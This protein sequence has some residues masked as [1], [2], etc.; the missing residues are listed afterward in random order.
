MA[1]SPAPPGGGA[2]AFTDDIAAQEAAEARRARN[3]IGL[4]ALLLVIAAVASAVAVIR[5]VEDAGERELRA[6]QV[7][8]GIVAD[9]RASA[10]ADWVKAQA[11]EIAAIAANPS[12][13]LTMTELAMAD[14][15]RS[16]LIDFDGQAAYLRNYLTSV[17]ER[18]G[19]SRPPASDVDFQAGGG[20]RTMGIA[21]VDPHGMLVSATRDMPL[22]EGEI[23]DW[24]RT[25][26]RDGPTFIDAHAAEGAVRIGFLAPIYR[27]QMPSESANYTGMVIGLR[28]LDDGFRALLH[29]PG[30]T[31]ET[32]EALVLRQEG[33]R[34]DV[35][36][37][38]DGSL[39]PLTPLAEAGVEA[40]EALVFGDADGFVDAPGYRGE[41]VLASARPVEGTPWLM[42]YQLDRAEA[43]AESDARLTRMLVLLL[44]IIGLMVVVTAAVWRHGAS[45]RA[46]RA[47]GRY[48]AVAERLARQERFL[49]LVTDTQPSAMFVTDAHGICRF[50]N[51]PLARRLGVGLSDIVGATLTAVFGKDVARDYRRAHEDALEQNGMVALRRTVTS[52]DR[53]DRIVQ[54]LHVPMKGVSPEL[55][56]AV[57]T[58]EEDITELMAER[59]RNSRN[60]QKL[61]DTLVTII[62]ARDPYAARHSVRVGEIAERVAREMVADQSVVA[63][64]RIAGTLLNVGKILVP[65]AL[66]TSDRHLDEA[67]MRG[68]RESILRGADLLEGV[69]F[70]GPVAEAI[71]QAQEHVDG[72]GMPR[73]LA[74]DAI[75]LPARIVAVANAFV[76]LV[77][78]RAHR[79]G[80]DIDQALAHIQRDV[81]KVFDRSVVSALDNVLDNRG[82]R[83]IVAEWVQ[84][85]PVAELPVRQGVAVSL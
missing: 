31:E 61:V 3:K 4:F 27:L 32:A 45:V 83:A 56:G 22:I 84:T 76:A 68:V 81:G 78:P 63:T 29:Q 69:A 16:Q 28:P 64:T 17:A 34:I 25:A 23:A 77:S 72:S 43:L 53:G 65:S 13:A 30:A 48:H 38:T 55:E 26:S 59:E 35:V 15:D 85:S 66:L 71:R 12:V 11:D 57:L 73:G 9:S 1:E 42:S 24:I 41:Q 80:L 40:A 14:G 51:A 47:A 62:D 7:R 67:E 58:V 39:A 33:A 54:A 50:A 2:P 6:W 19:F 82:G 5:M 60:L 44:L 18:A 20:P 52:A 8:L 10:V 46:T 49:R 36:A 75:M 37:S 70:D 79:P 21:I 74:G